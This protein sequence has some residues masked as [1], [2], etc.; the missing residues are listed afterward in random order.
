MVHVADAGGRASAG[1]DAKLCRGRASS[2]ANNSSRAQAARLEV[3]PARG[4]GMMTFRTHPSAWEAT[5]RV[6]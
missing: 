6:R 2:S 4:N 1:R 3:V 5:G